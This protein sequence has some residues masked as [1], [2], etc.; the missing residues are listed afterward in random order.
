MLSIVAQNF[1][2]WK[3]LLFCLGDRCK[4]WQPIMLCSGASTSKNFINRSFIQK[5]FHCFSLL[6]TIYRII[7]TNKCLATTTVF[8]LLITKT[9]TNALN[10]FVVCFY[11]YFFTFF[12]LPSSISGE[13]LSKLWLR[14][15]CTHKN[16]MRMIF[17]SVLVTH[18]VVVLYVWMSES[19][20]KIE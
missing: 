17:K 1:P 5:R 20:Q 3:S 2:K 14:D 15:K 12:F 19:I 13:F 18:V 16:K 10:K 4:S 6:N 8:S 7:S 11:V 9:N